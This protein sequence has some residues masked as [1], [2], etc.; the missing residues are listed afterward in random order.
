MSDIKQYNAPGTGL[1]QGT[2]SVY[3]NGTSIHVIQLIQHLKQLQDLIVLLIKQL[4]LQ[5]QTFILLLLV[6]AM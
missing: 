1:I 6:M 2:T 3:K 5:L 4:R